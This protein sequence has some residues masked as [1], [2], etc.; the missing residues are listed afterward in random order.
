MEDIETRSIADL[1]TCATICCGLLHLLFVVLVSSIFFVFS[2][3]F[4]SHLNSQRSVA[5]TI[6][7]LILLLFIYKEGKAYG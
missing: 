3:S 7:T 6:P 4:L 2:F 5:V 1:Q